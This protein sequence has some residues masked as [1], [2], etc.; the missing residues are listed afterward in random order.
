MS[1]R[2]CSKLAASLF[3]S[4]CLL[5][6]AGPSLAQDN[7]FDEARFGSVLGVDQANPERGVLITGMLFFDPWDHDNATGWSKFTRPRIHIGGDVSTAGETNQ[8]YAGFSWTAHLNDT[9]FLEAGFGGSVNDGNLHPDGSNS[10]A[11]GCHTLFHEYLAAGINLDK[12]WRLVGT[13]EHSSHAG[14]CGSDNSGL[15]RA[16]LMVGYKF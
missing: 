7:I 13:A 1:Q 10:P 14:L 15:T 6:A 4:A 16:G 2:A 11:L 5:I 12:N 3:A 9:F 8:I